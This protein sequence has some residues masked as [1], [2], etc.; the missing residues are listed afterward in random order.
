[1]ITQCKGDMLQTTHLGLLYD[2]NEHEDLHPSH[3]E[4]LPKSI[5][6]DLVK[7]PIIL[8][9]DTSAVTQQDDLVEFR[10]QRK[11]SNNSL[12]SKARYCCEL[13]LEFQIWWQQLLES[14]NLGPLFTGF[15]VPT[16]ADHTD[17]SA[18]HSYAW[19]EN[20]GSAFFLVRNAH[21][22][23]SCSSPSLAE[24]YTSVLRS[25]EFTHGINTMQRVC[26][27]TFCVVLICTKCTLRT[28][29][30]Y[31]TRQQYAPQANTL[32]TEVGLYCFKQLNRWES[33]T[34]SGV[35]IIRVHSGQL[36]IWNSPYGKIPDGHLSDIWL[37]YLIV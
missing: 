34:D 11:N 6:F 29:G 3:C 1:M 35:F 4:Q 30:E 36:S 25:S 26:V 8:C 27:I 7:E 33:H 17:H 2:K 18:P 28:R 15:M 23:R 16:W 32:S 22:P 10:Q 21:C 14:W 12:N 9:S 31:D 37:S 19:I 24:L 13:V 5:L 20:R